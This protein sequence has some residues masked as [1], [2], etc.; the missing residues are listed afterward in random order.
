MYIIY[1]CHAV[2][3]GDVVPGGLGPQT[4]IINHVSE[5]HSIPY[6]VVQAG[7]DTLFFHVRMNEKPIVMSVRT[8][9]LINVTFPK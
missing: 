8:Y 7:L 1:Y 9:A 6:I 5:I 4:R 2:V 3:F